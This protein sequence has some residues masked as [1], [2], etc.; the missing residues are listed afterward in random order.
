MWAKRREGP[1]AEYFDRVLE[2]DLWG[3]ESWEKAER[4]MF[5][6][7]AELALRKAKRSQGHQYLFGG[8]LLDQIVSATFPPGVW[9]FLS[10]VIWGMLLYDSDHVFIAQLIDGDTQIMSFVLLQ[11][12]L[13]CRETIPI[14]FGDGSTKAPT[15]NGL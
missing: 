2:D 7:A 8:D 11:P 9:E 13:F 5:I 12:F 6:E 10:M 3:E 4:R 1:L 15:L 14:S